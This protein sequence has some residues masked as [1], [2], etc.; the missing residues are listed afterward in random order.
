MSG[1]SSCSSRRRWVGGGPGDESATEAC[2]GGVRLS[3]RGGGPQA[4]LFR[5]ARRRRLLPAAPR[6]GASGAKLLRIDTTKLLGL[7]HSKDF[8]KS[9]SRSDFLEIIGEGAVI[10]VLELIMKSLSSLESQ[11]VRETYRAFFL[12]ILAVGSHV[13]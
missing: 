1:W 4:P 2:G 10:L 7:V 13:T 9:L 3:T 8:I 12:S 5:G 6:A 11:A